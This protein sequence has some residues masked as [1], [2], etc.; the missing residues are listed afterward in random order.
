MD[1]TESSRNQRKDPVGVVH[2]NQSQGS[3][4]QGEQFQDGARCS[5]IQCS[6]SHCEQF[7]DGVRCNRIP[8]DL[9]SVIGF[10]WNWIPLDDALDTTSAPGRIRHQQS[11][12]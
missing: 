2:C 9:T 10:S 3:N 1:G 7:Q 6:N 12:K 4:S 11:S 5:R 8:A